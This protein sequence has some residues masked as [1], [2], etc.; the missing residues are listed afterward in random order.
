MK[1]VKTFP[2][3]LW[4][5]AAALFCSA[6]SA[7]EGESGDVTEFVE[8]VGNPLEKTFPSGERIHARNIWDLQVFDGKLYLGHG[9]ST[10]NV[11]PIDVW[12]YSPQSGEFTAE[13]R[14][15]DHSIGRYRIINGKLCIPG[16]DAFES[17]DFGNFYRLE[18]EG[19]KKYR[20]LENAIHCIDLYGFGGE[21]FAAL[22]AREGAVV[23]I[24]SDEGET[25][26]YSK[27]GGSRAYTLF[28]LDRRL[29]VSTSANSLY[30]YTGR[31]FRPA[32]PMTLLVSGLKYSHERQIVDRP[33]PFRDSLVYIART[34]NRRDWSP[35]GAYS[36]TSLEDVRSIEISGQPFDI[37]AWNDSCY[38]LSCA[39]QAPSNE[40]ENYVVRVYQT[41]DLA[42]WTE[43]LRF[44]CA[45]FA[46]SF[47][48]LAGDFYFG[49]GCNASSLSESAGQILRV[50][51]ESLEGKA[52]RE[53]GPADKPQPEE[54][55]GDD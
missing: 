53:Q 45:T 39:E 20:N 8:R 21:L 23:A 16:H 11:S 51:K 18:E 9:D 37:V 12:S 33:V 14:L 28:E 4:S 35:V 54:A 52:D 27:V 41:G 3:L 1:T 42:Q 19:W 36:A 25:W 15:A 34:A 13:F 30:G 44:R 47:E 6:A 7:V 50:R 24:S 31:T 22:G 10:L 48:I 49:L 17:W 38:L 32:G 2:P 46:R 40:G 29:Y 55:M 26:E 43:I 5:L